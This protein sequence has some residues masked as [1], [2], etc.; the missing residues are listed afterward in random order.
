MVTSDGMVPTFNAMTATEYAAWEASPNFVND[1]D[2][3]HVIVGRNSFT[4]VYDL[5]GAFWAIKA[6][7][8][9]SFDGNW[10]TTLTQVWDERISVG[11]TLWAKF[12]NL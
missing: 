9:E 3:S 12:I 10:D 11:D 4:Y 7:P 8:S 1:E 2:P 5:T 6:Q